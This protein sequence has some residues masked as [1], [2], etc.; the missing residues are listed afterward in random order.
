[1]NS[2]RWQA[3]EN[4]V[5]GQ[6]HF[7]SAHGYAIPWGAVI[8]SSVIGEAAKG[9]V[10]E[11]VWGTLCVVRLRDSL[12]FIVKERERESVFDS[13][14]AKSVGSV[15]RIGSW[16]VGA[17][18]YEP[19]A[20]RLVASD[21][22]NLLANM[23]N[24]GTILQ[25]NITSSAWSGGRKR[26]TMFPVTTSGREKSPA[27]VPSGIERS[28]SVAMLRC[29]SEESC[30]ATRQRGVDRTKSFRIASTGR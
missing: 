23:G 14:L 30:L 22:E 18:R 9:V 10:E 19:D 3:F 24:I 4:C 5:E 27:G 7:A 20:L 2:G 21:A 11:E 28:D 25:M 6:A 16:V 12:G 1:L 15:F 29:C 17:D 26:E 13:H 8:E